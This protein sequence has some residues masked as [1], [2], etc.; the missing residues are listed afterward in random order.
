MYCRFSVDDS[1]CLP[2]RLSILLKDVRT[3]PLDQ[4]MPVQNLT[5]QK[6]TCHSSISFANFCSPFLTKAQGMP[7]DLRSVWTAKHL[8]FVCAD[9][10]LAAPWLWNRHLRT[11]H[12]PYRCRS[13][14]K[15][16]CRRRYA[17]VCVCVW[18]CLGVSW[19]RPWQAPGQFRH[20]LGWRE[21][22][23]SR[24]VVLPINLPDEHATFLTWPD[25]RP[26]PF[27]AW[28]SGPNVSQFNQEA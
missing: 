3:V 20:L 12:T 21:A 24:V 18:A 14:K 25:T 23:R 4:T 13:F 2:V 27:V 19:R 28:W 26:Q 1:S 6:C 10:R 17:C 8:G 16:N 15:D 9:K 22:W 11:S 5:L 7:K